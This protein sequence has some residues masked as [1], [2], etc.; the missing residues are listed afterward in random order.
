MSRSSIDLD[1]FDSGIVQHG[2]LAAVPAHACYLTFALR[3]TETARS[4]LHSAA[5]WVDGDRCVLGI[6]ESL[7]ESLDANIPGLRP[8]PSLVGAGVEVPASRGAL[9]IWLR[10]EIGD[11]GE[12][13]LG[14]RKICTALGSAFD[15]IHSVDAFKHDIGRDLTGYE[16]G[17]ENPEGDAAIAAAIVTSRGHGLDGSSFVAVQQWQ[18]ELHRFES[19]STEEQDN[20][21]GRRRV[22]NEELEDAPESSHVKRTAQESFSPEAFV[23]RRSMPWSAGMQHGLMFVAF[24]NS[25]DAFEA[26]LRRMAGLDDGIVDALF[27]FTRPLT[28]NYFWC[29]PMRNGKLDLSALGLSA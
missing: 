5:K 21:M 20:A 25:F 24:G 6:G 7:V 28:G 14:A 16:D 26:Q 15:L 29:P 1:N 10:G 22:D 27:K 8:F 2:V 17:T 11:R 4:A 19:M 18:H 23:L 9:W 3:D 13:V 12:L